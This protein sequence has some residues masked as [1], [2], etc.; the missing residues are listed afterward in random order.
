MARYS[1]LGLLPA[2]GRALIGAPMSLG[3]P[4]ATALGAILVGVA[5]AVRIFERQE[6]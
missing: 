5:A 4:V 1:F 2:M 6:L 3:W